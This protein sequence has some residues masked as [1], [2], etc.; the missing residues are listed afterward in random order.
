MIMVHTKPLYLKKNKRDI[1]C[2]LNA[3]CYLR[4]Q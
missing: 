2:L 1:F 4:I 3:L